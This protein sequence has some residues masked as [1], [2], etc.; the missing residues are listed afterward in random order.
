[1]AEGQTVGRSIFP[2]GKRAGKTDLS[3]TAF[4]HRRFFSALFTDD[5]GTHTLIG[6]EFEEHAVFDAPI[7]DHDLLNALF[8]GVDTAIQLGDHAA[9]HGAVL[10]QARSILNA[11]GLDELAFGV[12]HPAT[13]VSMIRRRA[14]NAPATA[15]ATASA[16]M[17]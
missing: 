2:A 17:L 1:M 3:K 4:P 14:R 8:D 10:V 13:S 16:L 12:K 11:D 5:F 15:P 7:D 9:G 6:E